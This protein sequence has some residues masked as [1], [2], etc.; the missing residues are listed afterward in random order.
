MK[1][2]KDKIRNVINNQIDTQIN[3]QTCSLIRYNFYRDV[4]FSYIFANMV[5]LNFYNNFNEKYQK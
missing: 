3:K 4:G 5:F 2:I 1:F